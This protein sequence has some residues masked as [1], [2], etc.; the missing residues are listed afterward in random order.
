V[1]RSDG[2][3]RVR[4]RRLLATA[5][6]CDGDL[7]RERYRCADISKGDDHDPAPGRSQ[8]VVDRQL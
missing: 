7:R 1:V 2:S 6:L 8:A 4:D 5:L 3:V